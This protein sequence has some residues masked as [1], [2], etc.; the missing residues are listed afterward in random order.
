MSLTWV[1]TGSGE[2]WTGSGDTQQVSIPDCQGF[3]GLSGEGVEAVKN[4]SAVSGLS[5]YH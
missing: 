2:K 1:V 5:S 4:D 3:E